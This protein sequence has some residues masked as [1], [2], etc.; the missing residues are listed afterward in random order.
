MCSGAAKIAVQVSLGAV[1]LH[2]TFFSAAIARTVGVA[3]LPSPCIEIV[4]I[5]L[6]VIVANPML[7]LLMLVIAG[8][9]A[10]GWS[11]C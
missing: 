7:L 2:V 5:V 8:G 6:S 9:T 10:L 11:C 4:L 3:V 1:L